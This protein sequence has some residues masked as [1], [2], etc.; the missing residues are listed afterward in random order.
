[1]ITE[2]GDKQMTENNKIRNIAFLST[3]PPRECGLATFTEDL[4]NEIDKI[5]FIRSS[6]I[7]VGHVEEYIDSRVKYKLSQHDRASY[8][9]T[10][11]WVNR[12]VDLLVIEHEYGIF[13]GEC[14]EY[15][16]DL[17]KELKIPFIVTTHTVLQEPSAKQQAVLRDLGSLSTKMVVMAE[18]SIPIL[19]ETY[20]IESRKIVFIPHG[21]PNMRMESREKLKSKHGLRNKK[22]VSSFGLISPAKGL[23]YG[24]EAVAKA[25]QDH[26][27]LIYLILGKTHPGVKASMGENYRHSLMDLAEDLGIQNHVRFIDKYLTKEEVIT[28]LHLSDMYLTPY[29]SK[30]QAVSGTMAYAMGC[31][32]VIISTPYRYAQEMLGGG[33]GM[34]AGFKDA[35]SMASCIRTVLAN[36]AL[37]KEME[38]KTLAVG[39][40]MTW[41]KVADRYAD[42]SMH[43]FEDAE[44]WQPK[45]LNLHLLPSPPAAVPIAHSH[46]RIIKR[47]E[48]GLV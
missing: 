45:N 22:V 32:R 47:N 46:L 4:V 38:M 7:A 5:S 12:N 28:Y 39:R 35:D 19:A 16:L 43:I 13:G 30:E 3:Y 11:L 15:I 9:Q 27:D 41:T 24:I 18:S 21:V 8:R 10:A 17:A 2:K 25:V 40:T 1:M 48:V 42:L 29:L 33:R 37:Q 44:I 34:L 6:V 14:G 20:G 31:G 23:E 26:E 36:P